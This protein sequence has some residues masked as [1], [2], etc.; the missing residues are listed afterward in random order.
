MNRKNILIALAFGMPLAGCQSIGAT[1][2]NTSMYSVHQP[3]VERTNYALDV[4][5]D[6]GSG[7][8]FGERA[9]VEQWFQALQLGY[10]DRVAIDFGGTSGDAGSQ[11]MVADLAA[12]YGMQLNATAPVTVGDIMAG[13]ARIVVTR[14]RASVPSCNDKGRTTPANYNTSNPDKFGCAT[15]ANLA[16]MIADPEDLVR[17]VD[18]RPQPKKDSHGNLVG[19]NQ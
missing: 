1:G 15:N 7:I 6:G 8:S 19:G 17:G 14:S 2:A 5:L 3:V 10:G 13:T 18:G 11:Q 12:Q 9:R 16:A 4:N